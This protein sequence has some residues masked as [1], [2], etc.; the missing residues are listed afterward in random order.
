MLQIAEALRTKFVINY[1]N[2]MI[3]RKEYE[4]KLFL[5]SDRFEN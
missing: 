1:L 2:I 3:M 4:S 5:R